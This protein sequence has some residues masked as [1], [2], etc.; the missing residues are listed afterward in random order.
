MASGIYLP[1]DVG[2]AHIYDINNYVPS[3]VLLPDGSVEF[4]ETGEMFL[5]PDPGRAKEYERANFVPSKVLLPDGRVVYNDPSEEGTVTNV[6]ATSP[7]H[8]TEGTDPDISLVDGIAEG[9]LIRWN[10]ISESW[11]VKTGTQEFS[12]IVLTP[13]LASL[14]DAEGA[15]YYNATE[16]AVLVCTDV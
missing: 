10:A 6:T 15:M 14:I 7:I 3:K 2:R 11:E 16:K 4:Q 13:A 8:S 5:P 9:D 12:G 1:A